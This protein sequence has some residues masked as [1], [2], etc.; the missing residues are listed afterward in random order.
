MFCGV[1]SQSVHRHRHRETG[2]VCMQ[3][4]SRYKI[5]LFLQS[6]KYPL[7][8]NITFMPLRIVM[9]GLQMAQYETCLCIS[10]L[11]FIFFYFLSMD[12]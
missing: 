11:L 4:D 1:G 7:V 2:L 8:Y 9:A 5:Y 12:T 3:Q 6:N 10:Y